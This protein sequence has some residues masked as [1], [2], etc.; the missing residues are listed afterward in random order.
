[1]ISELM[2]NTITFF[3]LCSVSIT[4]LV[5]AKRLY[6][7]ALPLGW[8]ALAIGVY[9]YA[10]ARLCLIVGL[11][12]M[13]IS[14]IELMAGALFIIGDVLVLTQITEEFKY[15]RNR[16]KEIKS[17]MKNLK[18]KYF[19]R[20]IDEEQLRKL[21]SELIKELAEIEVKMKKKRA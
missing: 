5:F 4:W 19:K 6:N 16:Q 9:M 15:L 3:V 21:Y 11:P 7:D 13:A 20:E 10:L 1:M 8:I 14:S 2:S 17:I 18:T 12:I